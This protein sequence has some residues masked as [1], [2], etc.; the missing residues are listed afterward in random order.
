MDEKEIPRSMKAFEPITKV[1]TCEGGF[2]LIKEDEEK[3]VEAYEHVKSVQK[4]DKVI[5]YLESLKGKTKNVSLMDVET[6]LGKG[7]LILYEKK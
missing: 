1:F 7:V 2:T 6:V 3:A 4:I 5:E